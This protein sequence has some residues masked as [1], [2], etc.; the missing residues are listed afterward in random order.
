MRFAAKLWLVVPAS[1]LVMAGQALAAGGVHA[2]NAVGVSTETTTQHLTYL[3]AFN[4]GSVHG[5]TSS[6]HP[7]VP[8]HMP[9]SK[10]IRHTAAAGVPSVGSNGLSAQQLPGFGGFN[11]LSDA[12]QVSAG[13]GMY[14]GTQFDLE[15]PD[16]GLCVSSTDVVE[17]VNAA[18]RVFDR[19]GNPLT[20]PIA[21]AQFFKL[22]PEDQPG[23]P[24]V[25]GSFPF[26]PRCYFDVATGH[27]FVT[28]G[29]IPLVPSTGAFGNQAFELIAVSETSDPAG[30]WRIY[31]LNVTDDGTNGTPADTGCPCFGDQPLMGADAS[32]FY[33]T[34][35]EYS[36]ATSAFNGG[37]VYAFAKAG[38]ETGTN[39]TVT[40]IFAGPATLSLPSGG[41][42]FSIQPATSP[43]AADFAT[44][45]GDTEYF[46]SAT[47]WGAAPALGTRA[48]RVLVWALTNTS[49]LDTSSPDVSLS[50]TVLNSELYAQPPNAIQKKGPTP[51]AKAVHSPEE[52]VAA[53]DDRMNQVVYADGNLWGGLNTSVKLPAGATMTGDAWFI[54][55]P[56]DTSGTLSASMTK[57]GY[58]AV[59]GL[60]ILYPAIGVTS[61][62]HA[63]IAFSVTGPGLFPSTGYA[64]LSMTSG[65]G[66]VRIA[67]A[68][69]LP[70]DGF[71]GYR[72]FAGFE[73]GRWGDY[74]AA[75]ADPGGTIWFAGEYISGGP[76]TPFANWG[77]FVTH[78]SP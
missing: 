37:I 41:L 13:T 33:L 10:T 8:P 56:S 27:W 71:T 4:A 63:V 45:N 19:A 31:Q 62:G 78:V 69:V 47:D 40:R 12:N 32:G 16:Q 59:D 24:Q 35:N 53:N 72:A 26:D 57:Q 54:A 11:G 74:S 67:G 75:V 14:A 5:V 9:N 1:L 51:L 28:E 2:A 48:D 6:P 70:D 60:N 65:V 64:P 52:L 66:A 77:T 61:S 73:V 39:T 42:A 7:Q 30:T 50:F 49:S 44:V 55:A 46:M 17:T 22:A 36:L 25:F 18:L 34:T 23:P 76:R 38:L 58:L 29:N 43:A 21:F 68:G 15:P 20:P 3:G